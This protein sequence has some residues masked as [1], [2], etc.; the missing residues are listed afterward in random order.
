MFILLFLVAA[1]TTLAAHF[2]AHGF[3]RHLT[4]RALGVRGTRPFLDYS[5]V[6]AFRAA[7]PMRRLVAA[8]AGPL[9]NYLLCAL[10]FLTVILGTGVSVPSLRVNVVSG[11][12]AQVAGLRAGD[13]SRHR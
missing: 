8:A 11:G 10:G 2:L 13:R 3:A 12:P 4:A 5:D 9:A 6:A 1:G 7:P